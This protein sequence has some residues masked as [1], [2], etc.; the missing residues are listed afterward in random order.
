[1]KRVQPWTK[2]SPAP[3]LI[4]NTRAL[5]EQRY[6]WDAIGRRFVA[7][8]AETAQGRSPLSPGSSCGTI[9]TTRSQRE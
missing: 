4:G 3:E 7:L 9:D 1:M 6:D 5:V 8:V 2:S